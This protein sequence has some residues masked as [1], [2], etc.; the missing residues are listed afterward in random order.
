MNEIEKSHER[1]SV[2]E[3][4]S[5]HTFQLTPAKEALNNQRLIVFSHGFSVTGTESR[6]IF[7]DISIRLAKLGF[8]C[9]LFD[10]RGNGYSDL[11]FD[12]MTFD[13]Q[14]ADLRSV[15]TFYTKKYPKHSVTLWGLSFGTS[16]AAMVTA[17]KK[18]KIESMVLWSLSAEL[19]QRYAER[20]GPEIFDKGYVLISKG[21][22]LSVDFVN[23]LEQIDTY[24]SIKESDV[25]CLVVHGD[26]D[27]I[28]DVSLAY[29]SKKR[30]PKNVE[31]I[32]IPGGSHGFKFQP[33]LFENAIEM[34]FK[35]LHQQKN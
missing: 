35:W 4:S 14:L 15:L 25:P 34:T 17:E 21:D 9:V 22:K 13:T 19:H 24:K 11:R 28:A 20:H 12:E 30:S 23:S 3:R 29:E 32:I 31:L 33:A 5:V 2:N 7:L 6:R 26:D 8:T 1:I 27:K 10:Y 18:F 16:V